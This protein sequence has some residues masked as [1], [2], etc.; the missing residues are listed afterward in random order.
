MSDNKY[1]SSYLGP[2]HDF[3]CL[4]GSIFDHCY[5]ILVLLACALPSSE[6]KP[7]DQEQLRVLLLGLD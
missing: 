5:I 1:Y 2:Q 4:E 7:G 3:R 6:Q